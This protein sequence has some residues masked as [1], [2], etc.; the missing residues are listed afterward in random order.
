MH[1]YICVGGCRGLNAYS[2]MDVDRQSPQSFYITKQL[3]GA[4]LVVTVLRRAW[5]DGEFRFNMTAA[6]LILYFPARKPTPQSRPSH[7]VT[8]CCSDPRP[9]DVIRAQILVSSVK[10]PRAVSTCHLVAFQTYRLV[11]PI[12]YHCFCYCFDHISTKYSQSYPS[13]DVTEET[14]ILS[15]LSWSRG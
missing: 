7:F 8:C 2:M 14:N 15:K 5:E 9:S 11:K 4:G 6:R 12:A 3:Y 13:P 10:A 1:L